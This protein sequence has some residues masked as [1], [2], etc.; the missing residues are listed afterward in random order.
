MPQAGS[1]EILDTAEPHCLDAE[2]WLLGSLIADPSIMPAGLCAR[3]AGHASRPGR[4][5]P[6]P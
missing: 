4:S 2:R 6:M 3:T 1:K 5:L